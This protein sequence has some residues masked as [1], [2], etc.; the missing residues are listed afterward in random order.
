[1]DS[2]IYV[3]F[4]IICFGVFLVSLSTRHSL[5]IVAGTALGWFAVG[6]FAFVFYIYPQYNIYAQRLLGE[7]ELA[8]AES[9]KKV[10]VQTAQAR[11]DAAK[12]DAER[13]VARTEG[14]AKANKIIADGLGGSAGYLRWKYIE[15]VEETASSPGKTVIYVPTEAGLPVLEAGRRD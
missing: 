6:Q 3:L 1:V 2:I 12:L 13:E 5:K 15:M 4:T 11:L 10:I 9:S 7:A 14:L 8:K